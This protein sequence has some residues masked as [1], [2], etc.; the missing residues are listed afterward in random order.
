MNGL[1]GYMNILST[2]VSG[3][4]RSAKEVI[5]SLGT[6]VIVGYHVGWESNL[7]PLQ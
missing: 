4:G 5:R 3:P 1:D 6:W 2:F 7:D